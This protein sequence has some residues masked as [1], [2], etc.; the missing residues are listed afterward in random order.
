MDTVRRIPP[1][2][3]AL[4]AAILQRAL[5]REAR[6]LT[7]GRSVAAVTISTASFS[8]AG[9]A[10]SRFRRRATTLEPLHPERASTLVTD[11][12]NAISRNPMYLGLAG[13]LLGHAV[14]RGSWPAVL[15]LVGFVVYIDRAQIQA[16]EVALLERFGADYEAYRAR[17]PR[18]I[19]RRSVASLS[20]RLGLEGRR[21]SRPG[22]ERPSGAQED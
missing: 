5:P 2:A 10:A 19:D 14:W 9:A 4:G 16:E 12:V 22:D 11:G 15:P 13:L 20:Q 8:M 1:P 21:R 17:T 18:W 7:T 6:P 3:A